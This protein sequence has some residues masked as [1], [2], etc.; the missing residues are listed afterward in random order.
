LKKCSKCGA[1]KPLVDFYKATGTRD[2]HR[3]DCKVCN[4][5]A[6]ALRTA[7]DPESNRARAR[8]W[9]R[10]NPERYRATQQAY[11]ESGK[12]KIADR[13]SHLKRKFGLTPDEF[14]ELLELQDGGC[15][16][17]GELPSERVSLHVDH[18]HV[19][20]EVRGILCMR[21]NN[22]LGLFREDPD[23]LTEAAHYLLFGRRTRL[24]PLTGDPV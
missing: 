11:L 21:C 1:L 18:D 8:E 20:G 10:Q 22:A 3:N 19:T 12:K 16:I 24:V 5:A 23:L 13:K 7:R 9:Q 15:A 4:L 17:C 14:D 2:G 6:K